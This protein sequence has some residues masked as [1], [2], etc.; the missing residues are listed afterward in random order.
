MSSHNM[1]EVELLCD[2]VG[3]IKEGHLIALETISEL[4]RKKLYEVEAFFEGGY[5]KEKF[6]MP[7]VV[8][9]QAESDMIRLVVKS[10]ISPVLEVL[11]GYKVIDL[12]V[13]RAGLNEIF[14]EYYEQD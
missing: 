14:L 11:A 2:R 13:I 5:E 10:E 9:S 3:I 8:I 1:H 7:G 6:E 4:R 12:E